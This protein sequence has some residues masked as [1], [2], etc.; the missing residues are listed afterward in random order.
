[1]NKWQYLPRDLWFLK[2]KALGASSPS[3]DFGRLRTSS[4]TFGLL[5]KTSDFFGN[6]QKWSCRLQ[7]SQHSQDKNLTLIS[8]KK[9]AGIL[10]K[11][12]YTCYWSSILYP[13]VYQ[14][15]FNSFLTQTL[16]SNLHCRT[17]LAPL[18]RATTGARNPN[19]QNVIMH[20]SHVC[21]QCSF[22]LP[23]RMNWMNKMQFD[24]VCFYFLPSLSD[25]LFLTICHV[26]LMQSTALE[27]KC[28]DL[29]SFSP[30][31]NN[32]WLLLVT[33]FFY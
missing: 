21:S 24:H 16:L 15:H 31:L 26:K 10:N 1:M 3:A 19:L 27:Q 7:K 17:W 33:L 22:G 12:C 30:A 4:E 18:L 25:H 28:L 5:R 29:R 6:L 23:L 8:Q 9:L 14:N 13:N 11:Q 32:L 2:W 20:A